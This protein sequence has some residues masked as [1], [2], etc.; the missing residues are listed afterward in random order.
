MRKRKR[1]VLTLEIGS[2]DSY[3]MKL[4]T[5]VLSRD[6]NVERRM[7]RANDTGPIQVLA[8][9]IRAMGPSLSELEARFIYRDLFK[10][11]NEWRKT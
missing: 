5:P 10:G 1:Y 3:T 6:R 11:C 7:D 8:D 2:S 9:F 4:H